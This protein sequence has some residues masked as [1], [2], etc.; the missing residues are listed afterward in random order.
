MVSKA[1]ASEDVV[2]VNN[3][4]SHVEKSLSESALQKKP[5]PDLSAVLKTANQAVIF[6]HASDF[7]KALQL[8]HEACVMRQ[9]VSA[10]DPNDEDLKILD[11]MVSAQYLK[12]R[13]KISADHG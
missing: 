5:L 10:Q 6:D 2:S 11:H 13:L 4:A 9:E 8:Y 1:V 3:T 7:P 12:D